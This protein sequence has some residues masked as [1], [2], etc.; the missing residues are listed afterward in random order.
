MIR[1]EDIIDRVLSY[2]P[3]ADVSLFRKAYIYAAKAH[4]G[5]LRLSG[6][7]Y[8]SHPLNVA[9]ILAK[10]RLDVITVVCGLLHDTVEDT[11]VTIEDIKNQFGEEIAVIIDGL[12]KLSKISFSSKRKRHAENIRKMIL[13]MAQDIRVIL[14]KL[15]DRL[16]NMQT[17]GYLPPEKQKLIAKETLEIYAPLAARLGIGWLRT[18]LEDLS[19]YYS[20]TKTYQ[21][22][23]QGI[24]RRKEEEKRYIGEIK[25][26]LQNKLE[27]LGIKGRIEGRTKSIFSIYRKMNK[28]QIDLNQIYDLVAFRIIVNTIKECYETLGMVH[29]LWKPIPGRFKDYIAM[30]KPNMYQSLHTTV[31]GPYGG[32][33]E[34]QIRTEEM[35]R[36]AE[37]GIAAHWRYKEGKEGD[38]EEVRRF[39]WLRQ[40]LEWQRELKEPREFLE[41]VKTDLFPEEVYVFT[42]KGDVKALPAGSTAIDFAY[43]IH[44]EIGHHCAAV[45]VNGRLVPLRYKLN[46]GDVVEVTTSPKQHPSKDWLKFVKT[47]RARTRIKHYLRNLEREQGFSLGKELCEKEFKKYGLDFPK[48]FNSPE[49]T[50]I[51]K[52]LSFKTTEDLILAVGYGKLSVKQIIRRLLPPL[53]EKKE[54]QVISQKTPSSDIKVKGVEGVL[55]KIARCCCPLPG[56]E[57]VGYIT[58]GHGITVHHANCRNLLSADPNRL[59]EVTWGERT[60]QVY[61]VKIEIKCSD[62]V[63]LLAEISGAV[64]KVKA[65]IIASKTK[66]TSDH[67]AFFSFV[68]EV[69]DREQF[70]AV[71]NAIRSIDA[72][73]KIKRQSI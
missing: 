6:E 19:L 41:A 12:T 24:A 16:H 35:H 63:G 22:I 9:F 68:V 4:K 64:A 39:A 31:I 13:A 62:K 55:V 70:Q 14:V 48:I 61:P 56:D 7:P 34:I 27:D 46:T 51:A 53:E 36:L 2:N 66:T 8:L 71:I 37:E 18:E 40:I 30:P 42:P 1:I 69:K 73:E 15:A 52:K 28:Q 11:L 45:K 65:N 20:D 17:L 26:I 23:S 50:K 21:R 10:M 67:R 54:K 43:S 33:I 72:V 29:S 60:N 59:V 47:P 57:I 5:Q 32:R 25:T 3:N 38:E 44:S 58:K 49:F